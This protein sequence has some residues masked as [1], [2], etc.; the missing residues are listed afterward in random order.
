VRGKVHT[1]VW[2]GN[3]R[4]EEHL[5]DPNVDGRIILRRVFEKWDEG[6]E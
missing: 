5:K 2:C 6:M 3:L 4:Q 1:G